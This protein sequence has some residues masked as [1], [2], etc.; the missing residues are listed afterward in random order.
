M[1]DEG[2]KVR[3]EPLTV[4]RELWR[5]KRQQTKQD[6][7]LQLV[8]SQNPVRRPSLGLSTSIIAI[9]L[10]LALIVVLN[11]H[12]PSPSCPRPPRPPSSTTPCAPSLVHPTPTYPT[13]LQLSDCHP[14]SDDGFPRINF[15]PQA[16]DSSGLCKQTRALCKTL[17]SP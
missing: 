8:N 6:L 14:D 16:L 7:Q 3:A 2:N 17:S 11:P 1:L 9:A 10:I 12:P 5:F 4:E 15:L 13:I